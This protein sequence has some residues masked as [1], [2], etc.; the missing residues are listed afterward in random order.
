MTANGM[1]NNG[2]ATS[3]PKAPTYEPERYELTKPVFFIG[4]M[5]AG[6]T[7]IGRKLARSCGLA[8][9]DLDSY[10][11]RSEGMSC[12]SLFEAYGEEGFRAIEAEVLQR[13]SK[14]NPMV[15]SC[16]GGVITSEKNR[17]IINQTGFSVYLDIEAD[18]AHERISNPSTRPLL[19]DLDTA[20][21]TNEERRPMYLECCD[22]L[23]AVNGK[24][25]WQVV[26]EAKDALIKAGVLC[27]L[28][29]SK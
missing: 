23:I 27:S 18:E 9:V 10:I 20:R 1:P 19:K 17:D 3:A 15:V 13:F 2:R 21:R 11:E 29:E 26:D 24:S 7:T 14:G 8:C 6:K 4:F 5:G 28:K 16:G 22:A 12:K 25:V